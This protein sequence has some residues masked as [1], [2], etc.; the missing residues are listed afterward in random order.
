ME[1]R[2]ECIGLVMG[3]KLGMITIENDKAKFKLYKKLGLDVFK[4]KNDSPKKINSKS[5]SS[6]EPST[7]D[8]E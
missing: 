6:S 5:K 3:S 2:E 8:G 4:K 7:D 1:L